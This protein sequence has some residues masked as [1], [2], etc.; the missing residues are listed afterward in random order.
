M[1]V[2]QIR[3]NCKNNLIECLLGNLQEKFNYGFTKLD[4]KT[5]FG[6]RTHLQ[7]PRSKEGWIHVDDVWKT[8]LIQNN[9]PRII[10][11]IG[12]CQQRTKRLGNCAQLKIFDDEISSKDEDY[13]KDEDEYEYRDNNGDENRNEEEDG[14]SE[15]SVHGWGKYA[16]IKEISAKD[17]KDDR[18]TEDD[19]H[20]GRN[21]SS[22]SSS[23]DGEQKEIKREK[24]RELQ[25]LKS[26]KEK[27]VD[28]QNEPPQEV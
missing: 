10:E 18:D 17:V 7:K 23:E 20:C 25:F 5:R 27:K 15:D 3:N 19:G 16:S 4:S 28:E 21:P 6:N 9:L 24:N 12:T 14:S 8:M 2:M 13:D 1:P 26:L 22:S 11:N